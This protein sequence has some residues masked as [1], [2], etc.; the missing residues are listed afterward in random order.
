[1]Q[2]LCLISCLSLFAAQGFPEDAPAGANEEREKFFEARI[3]PVLIEHCYECHSTQ[4][5]QSK[6]GLSVDHASGLVTGGDSGPAIVAHKPDDSLLLNALQHRDLEMPPDRKLSDQI[7]DDFRRWIA[8]GAFD[9]RT[10]DPES[11]MPETAG[12]DL[13]SGRTFWAFVPPQ[14]ANL[15]NIDNPSDRIDALIENSLQSQGLKA[16]GPADRATLLR[17]LSFDLTGLPPSVEEQR[18]FL[19]DTSAD[20]WEQQV[21]RLLTSKH[22][23]ERW[24][25]MWLDLMR[26][27]EDQAHIVGNNKS[28]FYPNAWKYR[29]WVI[30]AFNNDLPYDQFIRLQ[31]AADLQEPESSAD[32]AALGFI[33]LGPKYYRRGDPEVMADE[34]EDRID[35]LARGLQGLTVACA[36][37]HDHKADPVSMKDYYALTGVFSSIEMFNRPLDAST[38]TEKNGQAKSPE[39]ALHVVRETKPVDQAIMIRGDVRNRGEVVPRGFIQ[40]LF[41]GERKTFHQGS[42]RAEL[43]EAITSPDNP[44]TARVIVNRIWQQ[45]FGRGLVAT[46]SN[47]GQL[48]ERPSHPELLDDLATGFMKNGWSLKWLHRTIV[49]SKSWQRSSALTEP[50]ATI[51]PSNTLLWRMPRRR[52]TVEA[53][54]DRVLFVSDRL[55][56]NIG[57]P[58]IKPDD[59][60]ETRRTVYSEVSRFQ[61]NPL[62]RQFDFPDANVHSARRLET[63]TPLQKLFLMNSPF[64]IAQANALAEAISNDSGGA[65]PEAAAGRLFEKV[66]LRKP[67]AD[68]MTASVAFLRDHPN[69]GLPQFAQVMMSS[70]EFWYLD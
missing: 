4:A 37:C 60:Q 33:G 55:D 11:P 41:P 24:A 35:V 59:P 5:E 14:P 3:R 54:R 38:E 7:V 23:G 44:L 61:L 51:D 27:A 62:L 40:V 25:R 53:W 21:D 9:P 45:Y 36:R 8:D 48:G 70:N 52:L 13:E 16:N 43:A 67:T 29:D 39:K 69:D 56:D 28:L 20:A 2:S 68:E 57:G 49:M 30:D 31:L 50:M 63:T 19:A 26:Y 47:F 6:G 22:F 64:M 42:G 46:V 18:Q 65:D 17:R 10:R 12:I 32:L 58:S 34:W 66:L 1:M 15:P